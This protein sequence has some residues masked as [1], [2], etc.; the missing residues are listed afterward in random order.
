MRREAPV[1]QWKALHYHL[2]KIP[3]GDP[4]NTAWLPSSPQ[5]DLKG[6]LIAHH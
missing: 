1:V 6:H 2:A 5:V 3:N 4:N